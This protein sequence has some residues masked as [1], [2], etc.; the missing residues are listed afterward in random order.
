MPPSA[1]IIPRRRR[2]IVYSWPVLCVCYGIIICEILLLLLTRLHQLILNLL[3]KTVNPCI[4][5]IN[6]SRSHIVRLL[7]VGSSSILQN[8][9][10]RFNLITSGAHQS[11]IVVIG[12]LLLLGVGGLHIVRLRG[13]AS[14][15]IRASHYV[16]IEFP[17]WVGACSHFIATYLRR[18]WVS[19]HRHLY[20]T[21]V[22]IGRCLVH[23]ILSHR[24]G[25]APSGAHQRLLLLGVNRLLPWGLSVLKDLL[26]LLKHHPNIWLL[27]LLFS[28]LKF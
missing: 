12:H 7:L 20:A 18:R 22:E 4:I 24:N 3:M 8:L 28:F 11:S 23:E 21:R 6:R 15:C 5:A 2:V 10:R 17:L 16:W 14:V 27:L 25:G 19:I 13:G 9:N 1:S 26:L